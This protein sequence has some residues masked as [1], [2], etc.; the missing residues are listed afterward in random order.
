MVENNRRNLFKYLFLISIIFSF[1]AC[2]STE[3]NPQAVIYNPVLPGFY[4]DPSICR[5]GDEYYM[6]NSTFSYFPGI[7]IFHSRDLNNWKQIGHV[8]NRPS[9]I[10]LDGLGVSNGIFAP[11]IR[12]NNGKFYLITT[13]VGKG[14]NFFVTATDPSGPWSEP[15]WL[16]E[17]DGIDPSIFFDDNDSCYIVNNGPAP[18]NE[19]LYEGHRA[20]WIQR[21][22]LKT[23]KLFGERKI[24]VNGGSDI[25]QKPIWIEGPHIYKKDDSYFLCAAEG[26]TA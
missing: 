2:E 3:K 25:S 8:L 4:P 11:T 6:V 7:P 16:P 23:N 19:P 5:V 24:I 13:L 17:I 9:Q 15:V 20:I 10:D 21:F 18:E 22:D 12:Y 1:V 26:G 14:G